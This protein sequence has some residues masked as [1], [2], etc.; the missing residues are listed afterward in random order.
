[1]ALA[2]GRTPFLAQHLRSIV[3]SIF[4]YNCGRIL[5]QALQTL[6]TP[7]AAA[8]YPV[9]PWCWSAFTGSIDTYQLYSAR[10]VRPCSWSMKK[11]LLLLFRMQ[12][13]SQACSSAGHQSP[14]IRYEDAES[15]LLSTQQA[16]ACAR[17]DGSLGTPFAEVRLPCSLCVGNSQAAQRGRAAE[18]WRQGCDFAA[19]QAQRR[20]PRQLADVRREG[21][22]ESGGW[23]REG[24][25]QPC[26]LRAAQNGGGQREAD[27]FRCRSP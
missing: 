25:S 17:A 27:A 15:G 22:E 3:A 11:L 26:Q 14:L 8:R 7:A 10:R 20:Q 12:L 23:V 9:L 1:M 19:N 21:P 6:A 5:S 18:I 13:F 2:L 16:R 4:L 24:H